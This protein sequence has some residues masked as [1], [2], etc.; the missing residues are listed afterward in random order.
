MTAD[1]RHDAAADIV[2]DF[3]D[4]HLA[5]GADVYLTNPPYGDDEPDGDAP[6]RERDL[7]LAFASGCLDKGAPNANVILL[8]RFG[9]FT[10]LRRVAFVNARRWD[11]WPVSPRPSF[12]LNKLGKKG[13]DATE[14]VWVRTGPEVEGR[15]F[16]TIE[17]KNA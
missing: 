15:F 8:I 6:E 16:P 7:A 13:T 17:W 4:K 9:F 12:G 5:A 2:G 14:Y 1:I 3:R 11:V 10:A